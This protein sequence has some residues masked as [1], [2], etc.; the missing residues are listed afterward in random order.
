MKNICYNAI[1]MTLKI[2]LTI[3]LLCSSYIFIQVF[4]FKNPEYK[5]KLL[6]WQLPMIIAILIEIHLLETK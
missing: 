6:A 3:A 2:S 1:D 4:L 5:P